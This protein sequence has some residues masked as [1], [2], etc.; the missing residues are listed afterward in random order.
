[1]KHPLLLM[2]AFF[3][4]VSCNRKQ[5]LEL[6]QPDTSHDSVTVYSEEVLWEMKK[7][8]KNIARVKVIDTACITQEK[9]ANRDLRNGNY[10]YT[11]LYGLGRYDIS[12]KEMAKLLLTYNIKADSILLPCMRP[13]EGFRWH[14]YEDI[15]NAG[16]EERFGKNFID[17]L[18][19]VADSD[20][21]KNHPERIFSFYD[22]ELTSRYA[23]AK[24]YEE[25][26]EKPE[27]DFTNS[28]TYAGY[29]KAQLRKLHA[30]TEVDFVIYKDGTIGR[31]KTKIQQTQNFDAA[32][33]KHFE[34]QAIAFVK[35]SKWQP[36]KYHGIPVSS[37]MHL[38]LYNK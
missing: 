21:I 27:D 2:L 25:F 16:I 11:F 8:K 13:P 38:N 28:L 18:R 31:I 23:A 32:F 4:A 1:M 26:L 22:C 36:A 15:M 29:S 14:C 17:S 34:K 7:A 37:E 33:S 6:K 10:T 20:Y 24:T 12:H 19:H 9:R 3:I 5:K 30:N 35:K